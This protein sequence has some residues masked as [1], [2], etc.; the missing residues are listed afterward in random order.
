MFLL[1]FEDSIEVVYVKFECSWNDLKQKNFEEILLIFLVLLKMFWFGVVV[2]GM[3][4]F[5]NI[6][7]SYVGFFLI[8]DF[9]EYL[10][11]R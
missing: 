7:I 11:G 5:I 3:F 9:V 4:V 1:F 8:N 2:N 6:V 10:N